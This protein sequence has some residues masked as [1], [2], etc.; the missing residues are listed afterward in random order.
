MPAP[1]GDRLELVDPAR[2]GLGAVLD[3]DGAEGVEPVGLDPEVR[4][5]EA[6]A[7]LR[8]VDEQVERAGHVAPRR[9][10]Q[11]EPAQADALPARVADLAAEGERVL[12]AR[13]RGV[14][15]AEDEVDLAAERLRPRDER[16]HRRARRPRRAP[17]RGRGPR[18]RSRRAGGGSG[19]A[20]VR[21]MAERL[22]RGE[23]PRAFD[24]ERRSS[25]AAAWSPVSCRQAPR[26]TSTQASSSSSLR[27]RAPPVR[28]SDPSARSYWARRNCTQLISRHPV[29]AMSSRPD[30]LGERRPFVQ[31]RGALLVRAAS[32]VDERAAQRDE[33]PGEKLVVVDPPGGGDGA[34]HPLDAASTAPAARAASP[35]SICAS[36]AARPETRRAAEGSGV[37]AAARSAGL[38]STPSSRRKSS[39]HASTR[40][41]ALRGR[42]R[43]GGSG[44]GGRGRSPRRG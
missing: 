17:G 11:A 3:R 25:P 44:R 35:A 23:P 30:R 16:G 29:A 32:R 27:R 39:V 38:G 2:G 34:A 40:R 37:S 4:V 7:Q 19:R 21:A 9:G 43:R 12:E 33:R 41:A 18:P 13:F 10:D 28:V 14:H 31:R 5:R 42:P 1:R 36:T 15:V 20:C 24:P 6:A 22:A 8:R 26:V